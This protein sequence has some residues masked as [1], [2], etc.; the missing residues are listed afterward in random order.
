MHGGLIAPWNPNT[1]LEGC[2]IVSQGIDRVGAGTFGCQTSPNVA[3]H[4][5]ANA[6]ELLIH[7]EKTSPEKDMN[8]ILAAFSLD[9][10]IDEGSGGREKAVAG[11]F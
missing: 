6:T 7:G 1:Q 2:K 3:Y 10:E 5:W 9:E 4:D 8:E 11:L